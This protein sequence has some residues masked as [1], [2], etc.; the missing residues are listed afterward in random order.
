[1]DTID[2][3]QPD[4][5]MP[6]VPEVPA[7]AEYEVAGVGTVIAP[8]GEPGYRVRLPGGQVTAYPAHSG[9]PCEANAAADIA[10]AIANPPPPPTPVTVLTPLQILGRMAPEEEVALATSTDLTVCIVRNRL[11]AAS[12][13]RSDDP[14]TAEGRAILIA[15][16]I[17]TEE[18]AAQ[19][20]A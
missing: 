7:F 5:A 18:R 12:E 11:I 15:K 9:E 3:P 10:W 1:M 6:Q 20:F 17:I 14:R 8:E 2:T 4:S 16:G 13:V 19:I